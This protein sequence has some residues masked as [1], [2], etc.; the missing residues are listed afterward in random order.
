LENIGHGQSLY[1]NLSKI[2]EEG[3]SKNCTI[4]NSPGNSAFSSGKE[5][6]ENSIIKH[7]ASPEGRKVNAIRLDSIKYTNSLKTRRLKIDTTR[8]SDLPKDLLSGISVITQ[9]KSGLVAT[10]EQ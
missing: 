9:T 3:R 5:T 8:N 2:H 4:I 7:L 1:S 6:I 10:R